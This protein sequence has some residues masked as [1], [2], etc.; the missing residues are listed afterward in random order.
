MTDASPRPWRVATDS[1]DDLSRGNTGGIADANGDP[2]VY[3]YYL[4]EADRALIVRAVNW[5]DRSEATLVSSEQWAQM[6][7]VI[8]A[9]RAWADEVDRRVVHPSPD[10]EPVPMDEIYYAIRQGRVTIGITAPDD[11]RIRRPREE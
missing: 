1:D 2:V 3:G 8:D 5:L 7:A 4:S 9:A 6:Q 10:L 11:V